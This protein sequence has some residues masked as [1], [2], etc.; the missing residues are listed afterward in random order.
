[1][2][3][4][5]TELFSGQSVLLKLI[6]FQI[7]VFI[8]LKLFHT[9]LFLFGLDQTVYHTILLNLAF[10][11][12]PWV[13]LVKPWTAL[14]YM[15]VHEDFFHILFNLLWLYWMGS[16]FVEFLGSHRLIPLF[17]LGG[18]AGALVFMG[19][20]N[21]FPAFS[22]ISS[23][24]F[25]IG[26]SAGILGIVVATATLLPDYPLQLLFFGMVRLKWLALAA[27]ILDVISLSGTNAGGHFAH[28]GGAILGFV[29]TKQLK[30][31]NDFTAWINRFWTGIT[32]LFNPKKLKIRFSAGRQNNGKDFFSKKEKEEMLDAILDKIA[33]SGYDSLT[34]EEKDFLF[35]A[36]KD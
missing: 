26:A 34:R 13:L 35:K 10:P 8:F 24:S 2:G 22:Q 21:F 5:L 20:F 19:A 25:A 15:F 23:G 6:R 27:V 4:I 36:S 9:I 31:G 11:S 14:S 28:L 32:G 17:L 33:K 30:K 18:W 3:S 29:F 7:G 16:L 12:D 1:M